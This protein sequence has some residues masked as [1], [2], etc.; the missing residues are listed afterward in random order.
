MRSSLILPL[1]H[2][3]R[4]SL[5]LPAG[6]AAGTLRAGQPSAR[7]RPH[8]A[9]GSR[10]GGRIRLDGG[11]V[12]LTTKISHSTYNGLRHVMNG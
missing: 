2:M 5:A 12:D 6:G 4:S 11:A 7:P 10:H 9:A 1:T 8:P 3:N